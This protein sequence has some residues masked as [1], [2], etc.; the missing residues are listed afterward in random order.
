MKL[1][2]NFN[3]SEFTCKCGN[4]EIPPDVLGNIKILAEQLQI[5]RNRL[6]KPIKINSGYRCKYHND[7]TVKGSKNSQHKLGTAADIV[8]KGMSA[9]KVF[10]FVN[11]L[12][13]LNTINLGGLGQYDN[14]TH[15]DFRGYSARWDNR[16]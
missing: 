4:C 8:I 16:S 2:K 11:K 9:N 5:I 7:I 10:S 3:L 13:V 12:M 15:V 1:T 14:F 6:N